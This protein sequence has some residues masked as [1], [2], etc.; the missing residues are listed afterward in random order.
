M[1]DESFQIGKY[2]EFIAGPFK[3]EEAIVWEIGNEY[4]GLIRSEEGY[5]PVVTPHYVS[6]S[7]ANSELCLLMPKLKPAEP[8]PRDR[9]PA[10]AEIAYRTMNFEPPGRF[11]SQEI[12]V[13]T[14]K[15]GPVIDVWCSRMTG[16]LPS[17]PFGSELDPDSGWDGDWHYF[18]KL[19]AEEWGRVEVTF[20]QLDFWSLPYDDAVRTEDDDE[21]WTLLAFR[22]GEQHE[23]WRGYAPNEIE[24]FC[25]LL[26]TLAERPGLV[27][28]KSEQLI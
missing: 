9:L 25:R 22:A 8:T 7:E 3:G 27:R 16:I 23:I 24:D 20:A 5:K 15:V 11:D 14:G 13:S 28:G 19:S 10:H 1:G 26:F 17:N 2:V 18:R 4:L 12:V 21:Y 6:L